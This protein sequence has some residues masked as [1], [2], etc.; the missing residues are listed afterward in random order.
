MTEPAHELLGGRASGS[1]QCRARVAELVRAVMARSFVTSGA[2][3]SIAVAVIAGP[4]SR[5]A[6]KC[7]KAKWATAGAVIG[8]ALMV[9]LGPP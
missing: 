9:E 7:T 2:A 1:G 4:K 3:S 8:T 6:R 5:G